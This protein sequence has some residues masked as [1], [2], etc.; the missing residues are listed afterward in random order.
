MGIFS[1]PEAINEEKILRWDKSRWDRLRKL[2]WIE[3]FAERDK[4]NKY[5]KFKTSKKCREVV[6]LIYKTLC[7][8]VAIPET[9][10]S[11]PVANRDSYSEKVYMSAIEEFNK[12]MAA[13]RDT[14]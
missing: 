3:V 6:T 14:E 12:L 7:G 5:K 9:E 8:E 2:E 11:N 10:R 1:K 13:K 4:D